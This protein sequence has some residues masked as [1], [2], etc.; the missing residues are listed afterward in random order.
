MGLLL[1]IYIIDILLLLCLLT[2][3]QLS[4]LE[5]IP[6]GLVV[7]DPTSAELY[8][9]DFCNNWSNFDKNF[10]GVCEV[11]TGF[12][13]L[14]DSFNH[15]EVNFLY[16]PNT[17]LIRQEHISKFLF[18][19]DSCCI[20]CLNPLLKKLPNFSLGEISPSVGQKTTIS[21]KFREYITNIFQFQNDKNL[22]ILSAAAV[23]A[24]LPS[25]FLTEKLLY[26]FIKNTPFDEHSSVTWIILDR[27]IYR[28]P[29]LNQMSFIDQ[30]RK[31]IFYSILKK[32]QPAIYTVTNAKFSTFYAWVVSSFNSFE[33]DVQLKIQ[34]GLLQ[35]LSKEI[36][37]V[38][39]Y[40]AIKGGRAEEKAVF[41]LYYLSLIQNLKLQLTQDLFESLSRG[42]ACIH[43]NDFTKT[44]KEYNDHLDRACNNIFTI[45]CL[46][47]DKEVYIPLNHYFTD[48]F[49][50]YT[51]LDNGNTLLQTY[52]DPFLAVKHLTFV[53]NFSSSLPSSTEG[54]RLNSGICIKSPLNVT[55]PKFEEV[56]EQMS[57]TKEELDLYSA[58]GK[59]NKGPDPRNFSLFTVTRIVVITSIFAASLSCLS[60]FF[61]E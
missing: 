21:L 33:V 45:V 61:L 53:D 37:N 20:E 59:L 52:G 36:Q 11:V 51:I 40:I 50:I 12:Q 27:V 43:F 19:K 7:V 24:Y 26:F 1:S 34:L 25:E 17:Y 10:L 35:D 2:C 30:I 15:K 28:G 31:E 41:D 16:S 18:L 44:L 13:N 47:G 42:E 55:T 32:N 6:E 39:N 46:Y 58:W 5:N 49:N 8:L 29:G 22:L 60:Y 48:G 54:L 23:L 9:R 14:P 4:R 38:Q 3:S 57:W 56:W